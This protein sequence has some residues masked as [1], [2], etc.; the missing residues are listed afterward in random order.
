MEQVQR[1]HMEEVSTKAWVICRFVGK[2]EQLANILRVT[3]ER[4]NVEGPMKQSNPIELNESHKLD[5]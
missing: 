5:P 4:P 2:T 1:G 3:L